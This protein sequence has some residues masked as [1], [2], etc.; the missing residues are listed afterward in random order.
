MPIGSSIQTWR[1]SRGHSIEALASKAGLPSS[2][3]EAIEAGDLDPSATMLE[4]LAS[5]LGVPTSWLYADP[6]HLALLFCDDEVND[7]SE[8]PAGVDPVME[9]V[10]LATRYE[11]DLYVLLTTLLQSGDPKLIRAAEV[12]LRSLVKQS[13][14]AAAPWQSR[15]P[16]HFEPPSD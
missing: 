3:L 11:R 14:Q 15:P 10:L 7:S 6:K 8:A 9:R 16:G 1:L 12:S 5:G 13:K 4:C 2:S